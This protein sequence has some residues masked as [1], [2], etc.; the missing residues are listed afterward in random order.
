VEAPHDSI[1]GH[2]DAL[3]SP[4]NP[5]RKWLRGESSLSRSRSL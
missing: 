4:K 2:K 3:Q 5:L 1:A